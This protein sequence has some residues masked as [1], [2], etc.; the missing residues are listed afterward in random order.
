MEH[1]KSTTMS[2]TSNNTLLVDSGF[3][4]ALLDPRDQHHAAAREKQD[5]LEMLS[6][7]M[8][9]PI[10][11]ETIN[12]RFTRRPGTIAR[13]ES[14]I[15]APET[16]FLDDGPYRLE[17]YEDTLTQ[18]KAQRHAMSLVDSVLCAILA[19]T[20]VRIDAMLT[21]NFRDFRPVCNLRGVEL[22]TDMT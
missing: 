1:T 4:F 14:I 2:R 7:V 3:F 15:H 5:W 18:A 8:P 19:D 12:T 17:A 16:E 13:F 10:L 9:W 20:N 11:Y 6:I 22:L 21:F